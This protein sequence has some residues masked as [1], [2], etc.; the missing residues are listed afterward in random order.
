MCSVD[1]QQYVGR[2]SEVLCSCLMMLAIELFLLARIITDFLVVFLLT[3][4]CWKWSQHLAYSR[5][6][7]PRESKSH[8]LVSTGDDGLVKLW[9]VVW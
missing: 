5:R 3:S 4:V 8:L 7:N 2:V 6:W 9:Q 1:I